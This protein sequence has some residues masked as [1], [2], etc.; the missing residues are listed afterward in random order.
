MQEIKR[1]TR[2]PPASNST[3]LQAVRV[4]DRARPGTDAIAMQG[5]LCLAYDGVVLC[6]GLTDV[7]V[8]TL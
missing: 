8:T 4:L 6:R 7:S 5:P 2:L 3:R 1:I